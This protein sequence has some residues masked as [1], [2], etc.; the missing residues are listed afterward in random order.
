[1]VKYVKK[2][3]KTTKELMVKIDYEKGYDPWIMISDNGENWWCLAELTKEGKLRLCDGLPYN[4]GLLLND[5]EQIEIE[6]E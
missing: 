6:N 5:K 4:L 3:E 1:M 2:F